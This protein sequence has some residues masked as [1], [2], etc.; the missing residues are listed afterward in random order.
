VARKRAA[1]TESIYHLAQRQGHQR[2]VMAHHPETQA[3]IAD[4]QAEQ[5]GERDSELAA[6]LFSM[7]PRDF[8]QYLALTPAS[9][10][11]RALPSARFG[12]RCGDDAAACRGEAFASPSFRIRPGDR[13]AAHASPL[14]SKSAVL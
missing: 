4:D 12:T 7:F 5:C 1:T 13:M 2:E 8:L 10:T 11:R 14:R 3:A 9:Q 6:F